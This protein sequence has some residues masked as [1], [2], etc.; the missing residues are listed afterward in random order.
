MIGHLGGRES[1]VKGSRKGQPVILEGRIYMPEVER[2]FRNLEKGGDS[3]QEFS[4][5][6]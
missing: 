3:F 4:N 6:R 1:I 2:Q 5:D